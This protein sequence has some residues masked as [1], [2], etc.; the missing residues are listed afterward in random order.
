M[1][2]QFS[3][4]LRDCD[5]IEVLH[6]M[7]LAEDEIRTPTLNKIGEYSWFAFIE[8]RETERLQPEGV[9]QNFD[10][11]IPDMTFEEYRSYDISVR[12]KIFDEATESLSV[13]ERMIDKTGSSKTVSDLDPYDTHKLLRE[14][15]PIRFNIRLYQAVYENPDA[16]YQ[17]TRRPF[18]FSQTDEFRKLRKQ[19]VAL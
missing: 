4:A 2:E 9:F 7:A 5:N 19:R 10:R 14:F 11:L 12:K 3:R 17:G 15:D 1:S 13:L 18:A 6:S 16:P 8:A